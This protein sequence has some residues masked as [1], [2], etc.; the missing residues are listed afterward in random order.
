ML[1]MNRL[2]WRVQ[3]LC[4]TGS[5]HVGSA[6][7]WSWIAWGRNTNKTKSINQARNKVIFFST[8]QIFLYGSAE[9]FLIKESSGCRWF[10]LLIGRVKSWICPRT[11]GRVRSKDMSPRSTVVKGLF[12]ICCTVPYL[13]FKNNYIFIFI[14]KRGR[15]K[16]ENKL[17]YEKK[18]IQCITICMYRTFFLIACVCCY[19]LMADKDVYNIHC[20]RIVAWWKGSVL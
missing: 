8:V 6:H 15:Y 4:R 12:K 20:C 10:S 7:V 13:L 9:V 1:D 3:S 11:L 17:N 18:N 14:H 19:H 16:T 2:R 5:G